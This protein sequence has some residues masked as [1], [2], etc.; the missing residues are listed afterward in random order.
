MEEL[1]HLDASEVHARRLNPKEVLMPKNGEQLIFEIR[2]FRGP[3]QFRITLHETNTTTFL[4]GESAKYRT[5]DTLT[6]DGEARNDFWT[7]TG[8]F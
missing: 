3:P 4:Q 1:E 5:S 6:E 2:V 7:I 8:E